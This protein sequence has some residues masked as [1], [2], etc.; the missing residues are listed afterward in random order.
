MGRDVS[1]LDSVANIADVYLNEHRS[2]SAWSYTKGVNDGHAAHAPVGTYQPNAFGL[3]DMHGN[4]WEWCED[5]FG[6][7]VDAPIDGSARSHSPGVH[8]RISR[9]GGFDHQAWFSRSSFRSDGVHP[10][11]RRYFQGFRPARSLD[12]E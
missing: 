1:A 9:G 2:P 7:Y 12:L 11:N 3:Y 5:W 4:V 10:D 6:F 8:T